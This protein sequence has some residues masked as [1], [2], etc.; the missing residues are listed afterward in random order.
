MFGENLILGESCGKI[1]SKN[2]IIVPTFTKIEPQE[3]LLLQLTEIDNELAFKLIATHKYF[4]IIERLQNLRDNSISL[5]DFEKYD[6]EIE[7]ICQNLNFILSVDK[8]R[9]MQIPL[10][11]MTKL[12]WSNEND[13]YF[14]GLGESLLVRKK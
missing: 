12:G 5:K 10:N 11:L 14:T 4:K 9:R 8:Q 1:D 2:R 13:I 6:K 3:Q 7:L